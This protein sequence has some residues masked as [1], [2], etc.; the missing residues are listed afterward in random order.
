MTTEPE[1]PTSPTLDADVER[2]VGKRDH[3][4]WFTIGLLMIVAS[5]GVKQFFVSTA[6]FGLGGAIEGET[7]ELDQDAEL[8]DATRE[9]QIQIAEEQAK[10][11]PDYG[12]IEELS[13]EIMEEQEKLEKE[14]AVLKAEAR[15]DAASSTSTALW[16]A[17]IYLRTKVL[18]DLLKI[19]GV[20]LLVL[21]AL[22]ISRDESQPSH[23]RWFAVGSGAVVVLATL[24]WGFVTMLS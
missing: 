21:G 16:F 3:A 13:Q 19:A 23:F 5:W 12:E 1:N 20:V 10:D 2:P 8:A 11:E 17:Q 22:G 18:L 9:Q 24:A 4:R 15:A 14:Y 6:V 7:V